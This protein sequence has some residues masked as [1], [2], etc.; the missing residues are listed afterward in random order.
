[1]GRRG[2]ESKGRDRRKR[3]RREADKRGEGK[4]EKMVKERRGEKKGKTKGEENRRVEEMTREERKEG[5]EI[6]FRKIVLS[7]SETCLALQQPGLPVPHISS[8]LHYHR[9]S[10]YWLGVGLG[11]RAQCSSFPCSPKPGCSCYLSSSPW[12]KTVKHIIVRSCSWGV[13]GG[14]K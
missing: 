10:V 7:P 12:P 9:N 1:M 2:K 14:T 11:S 6:L 4:G 5:E 13:I 3:E 8:S